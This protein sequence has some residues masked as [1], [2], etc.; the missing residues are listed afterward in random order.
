MVQQI[1]PISA[2]QKLIQNEL[3]AFNSRTISALFG[4]DKFQTRNLLE[5]ME[6]AG[7]VARIEQGK[8]IL[9]GLIPEKVLSNPL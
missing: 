2:A 5:R 1:T 8:F 3:F 6:Q 9:L 4:L 7:L